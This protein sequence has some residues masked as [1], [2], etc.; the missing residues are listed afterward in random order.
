MSQR[1]GWAQSCPNTW[2]QNHGNQWPGA[3]LSAT[4]GPAMN[5]NHI[6][7]GCVASTWIQVMV[8]STLRVRSWTP[9][10][11]QAGLGNRDNLPEARPIALRADRAAKNML[12]NMLLFACVFFA[13]KIAQVP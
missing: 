3:P 4:I 2:R 8:A 7:L 9:A 12:E 1:Q 11:L 13:A 6:F 10:G 5:D